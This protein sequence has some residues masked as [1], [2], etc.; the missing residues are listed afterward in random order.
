MRKTGAAF[1]SSVLGLVLFPVSLLGYVIWVGKLLAA[2]PSGVSTSA[3]GQLS[4]RWTMHNFGVRDDQAANR[5]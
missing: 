5:L 2:E 3:Q 4:P 1:A